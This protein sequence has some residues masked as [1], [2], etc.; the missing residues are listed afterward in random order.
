M[1][2]Q[3]RFGSVLMAAMLLLTTACGGSTDGNEADSST[4]SDVPAAGD[5]AG[6]LTE[7]EQ[8]ADIYNT[9]QTDE[10]LYELAKQ[11]G[12]VTLYSISSR[13][14]SV[15]QKISRRRLHSV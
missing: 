3:K 12:S 8:T 7:W 6:E 1:S 14:G 2:I 10:E 5:T 15:Q 4:S 13:C 9:E 11:E